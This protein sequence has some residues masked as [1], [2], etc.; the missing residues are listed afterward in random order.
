MSRNVQY[1]DVDLAS[2]ENIHDAQTVC[3]DYLISYDSIPVSPGPSEYNTYYHNI[4][5]LDSF[6]IRN[7]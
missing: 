2:L 4:S 7:P 1:I 5:T 6:K 3:D